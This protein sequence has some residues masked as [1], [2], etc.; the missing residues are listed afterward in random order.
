MIPI[1]KAIRFFNKHRVFFAVAVLLPVYHFLIVNNASF[2]RVTA[3]PF[4]FYAVDFSMGF[5]SGFLPGAIYNFF[6]GIPTEEAVNAYLFV[7]YF[8][9]IVL[10]ALLTERFAL[11]FP[12]N[13]KECAVI[14][15]LFLT[16]PFTFAMYAKEFGMLDFYW[17]LFFSLSLLFLKN[18]YL[19]FLIPVLTALMVLTNYFSVVTYVAALLLMILFLIAGETSKKE[20][21]ANLCV[22]GAS[23]LVG[24]GLFLYLICFEKAN[25]VYS[26]EEFNRIVSEE[27]NANPWYYE[28]TYYW[29]EGIEEKYPFMWHPIVIEKIAPGT[30]GIALLLATVKQRAMSAWEGRGNNRVAW[31]FVLSVLSRLP[32]FPLFFNYI[33]NMKVRL[34]KFIVLCMVLLPFFIE[35]AGFVF[36]TDLPRWAGHAVTVFFFFMLFLLY[37]EKEGM[38]VLRKKIS[39]ID[40]WMICLILFFYSNISV[41]PYVFLN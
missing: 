21:T 6:V 29:Y 25:L 1:S 39:G 41:A 32:F 10:V 4:S 40:D 24:V 11:A 16:G 31:I 26:V 22:F 37:C 5:C 28:C 19:K 13:K 9:L 3:I 14:L 30:K 38:E 2:S 17:V 36:S 15:F 34:K 8:L 12:E 33:K 20:R 7:L 23:L 18:R 35:F 27:R